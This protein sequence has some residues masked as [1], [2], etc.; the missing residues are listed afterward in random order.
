MFSFRFPTSVG[1]YS[2]V[3]LVLWFTSKVV[4]TS[5]GKDNLLES[6]T[7]SSI[8]NEADPVLVSVILVD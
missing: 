2:S 3:T 5:K 8:I 7:S 1:S 4:G 6:K